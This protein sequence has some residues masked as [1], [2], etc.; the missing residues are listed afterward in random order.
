MSEATNVATID[1]APATAPTVISDTGS[2]L[3]IIHRAASDPDTDV[4]KLGRLMSMYERLEANKARTAYAAALAEMQP[5]LPVISERGQILNKQ[6]NVQST[7]AKWEDVNEAIRPILAKYGFALSFRTAVDNGQIV[8][9]GVLSHRDG[10]SEATSL[11]LPRDSS[12]SKNEVQ[13]FGSTTSYGKR[14]T[15]Y[16]LLNITTRG[17]DD[18][19]QGTSSGMPVT[20][21]QVRTLR[22]QIDAVGADLI[23]F[24]NYLRINSLSELPESRFDEAMNA[25]EAKKRRGAK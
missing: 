24:C 2:I 19:G 11:P 14:Y 4:D 7:Y 15:A 16:A 23:A 5:E 21:D 10:H 13:G 9:T 25:L 6:G 8:V 20:D 3:E 18:D 22:N 17:E 12:G 1:E